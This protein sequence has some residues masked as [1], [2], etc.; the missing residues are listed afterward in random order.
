MSGRR[1]VFTEDLYLVLGVSR[2]A[3]LEEVRR[4]G[5]ARQRESH[6][7]LGGSSDDFV[8]VRLAVEVLT[9]E[10]TRREHDAWLAGGG[11]RR[12][13]TQQRTQWAPTSRR[14]AG[15]GGRFRTPPRASAKRDSAASAP[16]R[17]AHAEPAT[18]D[19]P[20]PSR[21][22]AQIFDVRRMAWFR[23]RWPEQPA[24]WPP[25]VA[26]K[27]PYTRRELMAV[28]VHAAIVVIG[29]LLLLVDA[30]FVRLTVPTFGPGQEPTMWPA[31]LAYVAVSA[32]WL[33]LRLRVRAQRWAL[34]LWL[35]SLVVAVVAGVLS[36]TLGV[37][38][39]FATTAGMQNPA[40]ASL[41]AQ[42]AIYLAAAVSGYF[43]W[44]GLTQ[45][46]VAV[47]RERLLVQLAN[48]SAPPAGDGRRVWGEPGQT[49]MDAGG[50]A[51]GT[52]PMRAFLAQRSVGEPLAQLLRIP[53]VRIVHG[54]RVPGQ[55]TGSIAHAVISGR[56][57]ALINDELWAPGTYGISA[58]GELT[59]NGVAFSSPA[60]EF[61]HAVERFH[62]L[63][64]EMS[65]VRGWMTV[66]AEREGTLEVDNA[67]TWQRVRLATTESLLRE[68]GDW[69]AGDGNRVDR[70]LLRDLVAHKR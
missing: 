29:A 7:D 70:L 56:R 30:S 36:A 2:T 24:Y 54:L 27:R 45:R 19:A 53:G 14:S 10:T 55:G 1:H 38:S 32:A 21:I 51:G 12:V 67:L 11:S 25:A 69:L 23:T 52:N 22:P 35:V 3:S 31:V 20:P 61:P 68:V 43:A 26:A 59:H 13:R 49:A 5:R 39:L 65:A 62:E 47:T 34:V 64:G 37:M 60:A 50:T 18:R 40:F 28:S 57:V 16:R 33:T 58:D 66:V 46:R 41:L 44:S 8:R 15:G 17:S 4:V 63:F 6:P 42:A 9:D 48:E